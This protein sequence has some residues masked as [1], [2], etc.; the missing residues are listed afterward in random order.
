[1]LK[2]ALQA[3]SMG[4]HYQKKGFEIYQLILFSY[5]IILQI[6]SEGKKSQQFLLPIWATEALSTVYFKSCM[7]VII[8]WLVSPDIATSVDDV[9]K[10]S[11]T[12]LPALLKHKNNLETR[13]CAFLQQKY[14]EWPYYSRNWRKENISYLKPVTVA[15]MKPFT[16]L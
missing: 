11:T 9:I 7:L 10:K 8:A 5:Y 3:T 13:N 4:F 12:T 2:K 15:E 1:M 14:N 6:C 16:P